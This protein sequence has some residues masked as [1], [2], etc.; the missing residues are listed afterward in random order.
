MR[1]TLRIR[2][3][4][5]NL[6]KVFFFGAGASK[7]SGLFLTSELLPALY[8]PPGWGINF[9]L[10]KYPGVAAS[11]SDN[12]DLSIQFIDTVRG[13]QPLSVKVLW[14]TFNILADCDARNINYSNF[15]TDKL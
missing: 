8:D 14:E 13:T 15:S 10:S 3:G 6:M 12:R 2:N 7:A 5:E 11:F 1:L 9:S 4:S